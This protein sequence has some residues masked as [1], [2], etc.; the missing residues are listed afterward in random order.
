MSID[1][2]FGITFALLQFLQ[3]RNEHDMLILSPSRASDFS[4]NRVMQRQKP[5]R[6][7]EQTCHVRVSVSARHFLL[8]LPQSLLHRSP[9]GES[10]IFC[11]EHIL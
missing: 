8:D 9:E 1:L 4:T 7:K 5:L 10:S 6:E 3:E 11:L 2:I